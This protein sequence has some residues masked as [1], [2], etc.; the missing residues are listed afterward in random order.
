MIFRRKFRQL[1][2]V[3]TCIWAVCCFTRF[4]VFARD[5]SFNRDIRPIL[6]D[7]CFA[8]HGPDAD[9]RKSKLR[10]DRADG[11]DGAYR[12]LDGSAA[13]KPG[14]VAESALWDRITTQDVDDLMPP[15][16]A[17]K[18]ALSGEEQQLVKQWIEEGAR[19]E[20]FWAFVPAVIPDVAQ[21]KNKE[22]SGQPVD[23]HVLNQL[24]A[25]GLRAGEHAQV[26]LASAFRPSREL[27]RLEIQ[28]NEAQ[29]IQSKLQAPGHVAAAKL[30]RRAV[31]GVVGLRVEIAAHR[32]HAPVHD[33]NARAVVHGC[34]R[35]E[36]QCRLVHTAQLPNGGRAYCD[37]DRGC[38]VAVEP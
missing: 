28:A 1:L 37:S 27:R 33:W 29:R 11:P 23:L 13:I 18:K 14:S 2:L 20:A 19:Y 4:S 26:L 10:L 36:V 22:W 5:I 25:A 3:I 24:E 15:A 34:A 32:V 31:R 35:V 30:E 17:H 7:R 38:F 21:V 6:S 9:E 12:T 8:C 16:K